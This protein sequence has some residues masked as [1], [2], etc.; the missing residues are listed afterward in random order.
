MFDQA[1]SR[2]AVETPSGWLDEGEVPEE[3]SGHVSCKQRTLLAGTSGWL[4]E[5]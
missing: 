5:G 1:A 4:D 2:A 3:E